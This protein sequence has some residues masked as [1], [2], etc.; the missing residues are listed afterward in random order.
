MFM[1]NYARLDRSAC[2]HP[3]NMPF[4]QVLH[5]GGTIGM[6]KTVQPFPPTLSTTLLGLS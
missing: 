1:S 6:Q 3:E 4:A 2:A 5:E